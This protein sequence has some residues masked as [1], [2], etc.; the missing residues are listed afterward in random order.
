MKPKFIQTERVYKNNEYANMPSIGRWGNAERLTTKTKT[1]VDWAKVDEIVSKHGFRY[2]LINTTFGCYGERGVYEVDFILYY[3]TDIDSDWYRGRI[4]AEDY[5]A[6]IEEK[7][8]FSGIPQR[9]HDCVHELDEMTELEFDTGWSGNVGVFGS[10][11]VYRTSYSGGDYL[12]DWYSITNNRWSPL[13]HDTNYKL[14]K[15][16]YFIIECNYLKK[17]G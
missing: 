12:Y 4:K 9:L 2:S 13:I 8:R 11:D 16:V 10:S 5:N 7:K 14:R 17:E 3:K 6:C 15:G 1:R